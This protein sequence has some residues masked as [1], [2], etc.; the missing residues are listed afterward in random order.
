M[1]PLASLASGLVVA[2]ALALPAA[3]QEA[4][5]RPL[6]PNLRAIEFGG[7]FTS[8][9]TRAIQRVAWVTNSGRSKLIRRKSSPQPAAP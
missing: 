1:K 3:A 8:A 6:D 4:E 9:A 7:R 5:T 2:L